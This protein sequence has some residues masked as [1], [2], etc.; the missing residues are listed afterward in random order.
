MSLTAGGRPWGPPT[1]ADREDFLKVGTRCADPRSTNDRRPSERANDVGGYDEI[2][3]TSAGF[4][5][6]FGAVLT[7]HRT[8]TRL[9]LWRLARHSA[10]QLTVDDLTAIEAGEVP[11]DR[12]LVDLLSRLYGVDLETLLPP[13]VRL[14]VSPLGVVS[15]NGVEISFD[16]ADDDAMLAAYLQLVR[17]MRDQLDRKVIEL[18]REDV[19]VL[20]DHVMQPGSW[21]VG[22]LARLMGANER[23]RRAMEAMF[24]A[25]A[26]VISVSTPKERTPVPATKLGSG[27]GNRS[28]GHPTRYHVEIPE[29]RR[30]D[31]TVTVLADWRHAEPA[32]GPHPVQPTDD[33]VDGGG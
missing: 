31:G 17:T 33:P 22:E 9:Y 24:I 11:L 5:R 27:Q 26:N 25:G 32:R 20:A 16:P 2:D 7:S 6:R 19:D 10:G 28:N 15:A 18:R 1:V 29:R 23:E 4:A 3:I 8:R 12:E 30:G 14:A 21:I 13:R